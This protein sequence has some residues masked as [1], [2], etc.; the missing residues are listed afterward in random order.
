ML[1]QYEALT[2]LKDLSVQADLARPPAQTL[3]QSLGEIFEAEICCD[4]T[5]VYNGHRIPAHKSI[6][7]ARCPYFSRH[8]AF[9]GSNEFHVRTRGTSPVPLTVLKSVLKYLY[10]GN[11]DL[12]NATHAEALAILE[13]E[14]GIPNSLE[15]DVSFLLETLSLG[16]LRLIFDD[17]EYLCHRTILAS[18]SPFLARILDKKTCQNPGGGGDVM[19]LRLDSAIIPAKYALVILHAIYL[20]TL[21]F[22][23]IKNFDGHSGSHSEASNAIA[24]TTSSSTTTTTDENNQT[25]TIVQDALNL[26]EI[27][28]FLEFNLLAQSCEDMLMQ[29]LNI[30]NVVTILNWSLNPYGSSWISR[31]AYQFL[32]EEFFTISTRLDVLS[33][34]TQTTMIRIL[35]SDFAQASESEV[36]QA[37]IKWGECQQQNNNSSRDLH[38]HHLHTKETSN[39]ATL[40]RSSKNH[41]ATSK[42]KEIC[43]SELKELI[44]SMIT[45]VRVPHILPRDRT[46]E[47]LDMALQRNLFS[48][49]PN[50]TSQVNVATKYSSWDPKSNNG[51]FVRPR[52]FLPYFEECKKLIQDRCQDPEIVSSNSPCV[53]VPDTL[54]MLR[55]R[56]KMGST[57]DLME[58]QTNTK[59]PGMMPRVTYI[60][61]DDI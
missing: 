61:V 22:R 52:L 17:T 49:L 21:D 14:F 11:P 3:G 5:L 44:S 45:Q 19:D 38:H 31:Q 30:N 60:K 43:D 28:R 40:G 32:E 47:V 57:D 24:T 29:C 26:Y 56:T 34:L 12:L 41:G 36:P 46:S 58:V 48:V 23:L 50:F 15:S 18:R 6:L 59:I 54:Y 55:S 10:T 39:T 16:D 2:L 53:S 4:I 25:E 7:M 35:K 33:S 1:S 37:L 13:D 42:R 20:D 9:H 51:L 8:L 27:G